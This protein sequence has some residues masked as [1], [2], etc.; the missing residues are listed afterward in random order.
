MLKQFAP[1]PEEATPSYPM[2][3][4]LIDLGRM[5]YY[6]PR[7]SINGQ[8]SCN[9]C[10]PLNTYGMDGL[11]FSFG[12]SGD[13]VGRNSP[14]TYNAA[15]HIAQF[16]DGRAPDVESQAK[17]PIL[18]GGEMGMPNPEFVV[19]VLKDIP[20]YRPLF[21]AAFPGQADPITYDNVGQAIG[22][23]ERRLMTPGR[24]DKLLAGDETAF[25]DQEKHGLALFV[26]VGCASCHNGPAL[27]GTMFAKLGAA[28]LFGGA[29]FG[30]FN[31][32]GKETDKYVF[33][34]PS[35]RNIAQTGPYLHDGS[36]PTLEDMVRVMAR[37]QLGKQLTEAEVG[38]IVIFLRALTG[39]I[40]AEYIA[41]PEL[42]K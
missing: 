7:L 1:L 35:L 37:H 14:S 28:E 38:D 32:T 26:S 23:F 21:E 33:K 34:V 4:A 27:G 2:S 18:A 42:P 5:L 19:K 40:P 13:P 8:M 30:R 31:V 41:R 17:G 29:D 36:I 16:W 6:E 22:A 9:T 11:R 3:Q 39:E 12:H 24:F 20:G 10:H 15:L 25:N